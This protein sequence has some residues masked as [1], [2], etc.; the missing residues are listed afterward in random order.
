MSLAQ[1]IVSVLIM[2]IGFVDTQPQP[3]GELVPGMLFVTLLCF[4]GFPIFGWMCN[5]ISMK[6]YPL[7]KEENG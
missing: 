7:T 4:G 1:T 5:I 2:M 6:F 3:G